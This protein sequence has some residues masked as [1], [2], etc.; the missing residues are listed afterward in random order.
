MAKNVKRTETIE[1]FDPNGTESI[2]LAAREYGFKIDQMDTVD[3]DTLDVTIS[4]C[5][6]NI[7]EFMEDFEDGE[8]RPMCTKA[9]LCD[10]DYEIWLTQ[11]LKNIGI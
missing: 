4:G 8:V 9:D 6:D 1:W 3:E 2:H 7:N 5:E 10:E 11:E